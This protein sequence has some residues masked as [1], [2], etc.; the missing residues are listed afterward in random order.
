MEFEA[1]Y[2]ESIFKQLPELPQQKLDRY[3]NEFK[4][5]LESAFI[6]TRDLGVSQRFEEIMSNVKVKMSNLNVKSASLAQ[7]I[8]NFIINKKISTTLS[9]DKFTKRALELL[10]PMKTDEKV[11]DNLINQLIKTNKK[12]VE[13]Y[14]K[15][16]ENAVMFLVGQV[17]R[18]MKG[19]VD[20]KLV[21]EKIL[22][23]IK[24]KS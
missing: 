15:G 6:L 16:K 18:E 21:K 13:D 19:K 14:K 22:E 12:A 1:K 8:A 7:S 11:L 23:K 20:A 2:L 10:S 9:I 3:V 24:I 17:M 5:K 4:L